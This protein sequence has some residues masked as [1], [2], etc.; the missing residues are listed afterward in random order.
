MIKTIQ[1]AA[2]ILAVCAAAALV[3][4]V[5]LGIRP[6]PARNEILRQPSV[7][8][9]L[10]KTAAAA[11]PQTKT[12]PLVAQAQAL[13]KRIDPP[14]PPEPVERNGETPAAE[15]TARAA[16]APPPPPA[17]F[18]VVATSVNPLNPSES[19]ALLSQPG[20][21]TFWVKT[22]DEVSRAVIK[23]ILPGKLVTADGRE[24]FVPR[25]QRINLLKPG[26]PLPP[27]YEDH[28]LAPHSAPS[29]P[30]PTPAPAAATGVGLER[31]A[32]ATEPAISPEDARATAEWLKAVMEDPE[33]MGLSREEV[34]QIGDLGE[35]LEHI[36]SM[37][38]EP[39]AQTEDP[40]AA[41]PADAQADRQE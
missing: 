25:T 16:V 36:K 7:V 13:T 27:G 2:V 10:K 15:T 4:A 29:T 21:G 34:A 3:G 18:D 31:P 12:S 28:N 41:A 39:E 30:M 40:N 9:E 6:D 1:I 22:N 35:M 23:Q 37:A 8:E 19:Y 20:K 17:R 33:S 26:S 38:G 5:V 14:P 24:H 11:P 32:P